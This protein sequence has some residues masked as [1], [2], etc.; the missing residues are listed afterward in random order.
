M[1]LAVCDNVESLVEYLTR[2]G[3]FFEGSDDAGQFWNHPISGA[4]V[5]LDYGPDGEGRLRLDGVSHCEVAQ[6]GAYVVG[7]A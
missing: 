4:E 1:K 7:Y 3:W 2:E 5:V 6:M